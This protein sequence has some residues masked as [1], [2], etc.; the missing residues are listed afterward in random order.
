MYMYLLGIGILLQLYVYQGFYI[1]QGMYIYQRFSFNCM[2]IRD[3]TP[4]Y[5]YLPKILLQLYQSGI[6]LQGMYI[7]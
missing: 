3:S 4:G 7:Y 1:L 2:S 5:V 6:S